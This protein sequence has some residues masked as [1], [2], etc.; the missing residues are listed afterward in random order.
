MGP[1]ALVG[2]LKL[3]M[4][5]IHVFKIATDED[6]VCKYLVIGWW[7]TRLNYGLQGF[8]SANDVD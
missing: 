3:K 8:R 5:V 7:M 4:P 1:R 2:P 6:T